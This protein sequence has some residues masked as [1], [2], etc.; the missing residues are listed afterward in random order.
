ML[1]CRGDGAG[2][3]AIQ[4]RTDANKFKAFC[5]INSF[6]KDS[7]MASESQSDSGDGDG[8]PR[9]LIQSRRPDSTR[10]HSGANGGHRSPC[11][12]GHCS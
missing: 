7:C 10:S 6:F 5:G 1:I 4:R 11:R 8:A 12:A 2:D 9:Q 3:D